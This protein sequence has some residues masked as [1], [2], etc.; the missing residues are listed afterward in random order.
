MLARLKDSFSEFANGSSVKTGATTLALATL[1][2]F[3]S[4]AS[5]TAQAEDAQAQPVVLQ[6]ASSCAPL[7]ETNWGQTINASTSAHMYSQENIGS[8][9]ISI[10][11]GADLQTNGF[12]ADEL[13]TT[14]VRALEDVGIDAQCFVNNSHF[15]NSGTAMGFK[16]AGLSI[17]ID[18]DNSFNLSEVLRDQKVLVAAINEAKTAKQLLVNGDNTLALAR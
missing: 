7:E 11:P 9:G 5:N 1:L 18:G 2:T 4:A 6:H 12:T 13:G 3:S 10:F 17:T 14:L 15:E 16:V 8:I